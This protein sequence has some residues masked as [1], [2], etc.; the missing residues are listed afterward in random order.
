MKAVRGEFV[1]VNSLYNRFLHSPL[2][3]LFT[4]ISYS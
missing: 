4:H 1:L 2:R 3:I